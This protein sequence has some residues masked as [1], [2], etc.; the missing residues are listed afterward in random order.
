MPRVA[1]TESGS[2]GARDPAIAIVHHRS[3]RIRGKF[4]RGFIFTRASCAQR[5]HVPPTCPGDAGVPPNPAST[6]ISSSTPFRPLARSAVRLYRYA[7]TYT[8]N[9]HT[10][11]R[12]MPP[13]S[14]LVSSLPTFRCHDRENGVRGPEMSSAVS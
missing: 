3:P 11:V 7:Y 13:R 5:P 4:A 8:Y 9:V 12:R 6:V 2:V 10:Y 14:P 1:S